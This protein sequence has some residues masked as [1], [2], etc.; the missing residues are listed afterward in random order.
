MKEERLLNKTLELINEKNT[1]D[2]YNFLVANKNTLDT[3]SSQVYNF[4]YCLAATCG[5]KEESI[6][7]LE[8]AV[9]TKGL[10]FRPEVFQD[11]DLDTVREKFR[12]KNCYRKSEE[13]YLK[14]LRKTKTIC[15]WT[16]KTNSRLILSLHG[17]QQNNEISKEHW[18]FLQNENYQV[19]YIQSKELDSS[20]LYR[21]EDDGT[22]PK[23]LSDTLKLIDWDSY[24][25]KIL[26]GFSS[27]CNTILRSIRDRGVFCNKIILQSP[28]I[29]VIEKESDL[30]FKKL[31]K[32]GT[33]VFLICG[34]AD[35]DCFILNKLFEAKALK[36]GLDCEIH[37]IEGLGHEYPENFK[38]LIR[39]FI[40]FKNL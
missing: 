28:W 22:G 14:A 11:E 13:R 17:N 15:T 35:K 4:L 3:I 32:N 2:A 29:P 31:K 39:G 33:K 30:L 37:F 12:F 36:V 18:D 38:K 25:N 6:V 8:E 21:W 24:D 23:Q 9:L 16:K 40:L 27:G 26:C 19:E 20:E 7:W 34:E 1:N 10:W 5:K